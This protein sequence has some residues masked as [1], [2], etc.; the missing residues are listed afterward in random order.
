[1]SDTGIGIP[2]SEKEKIFTKFYRAQNAKKKLSNGTGIG[3][4]LCKEY[5]E[6][7]QGSVRFEST[8]N[9]GAAFF[10]TIPLKSTA[11]LNEFFVKA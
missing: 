3:L 5:S 2:D 10:V 6:A 8:E 11:K 9:Q 7:H 1:M 4:Y